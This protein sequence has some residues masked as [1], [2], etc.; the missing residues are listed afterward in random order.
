MLNPSIADHNHDDPTIRRTIHFT[1]SWGFAGLTVVNLYPIRT[2]QPANCRRW[3]RSRTARRA[4]QR[5]AAIVADEA[6]RAT[7]VVAAWGR[8]AWDA[9]WIEAIIESIAARRKQ[10]ADFYC[11]GLTNSGYPKHPLAR[12]R[13]RIPDDQ[14][15]VLWRGGQS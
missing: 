11:L 13:H 8:C 9:D 15:P 14:Q 1:H 2:P 4:L 12:G 6:K 10:T 5:N 3:A 7:L